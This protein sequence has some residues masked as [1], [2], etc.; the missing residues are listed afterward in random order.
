VSMWGSFARFGPRCL[1]QVSARRDAVQE[2][3]SRAA[4]L[5]LAAG[6]SS[7][8]RTHRR[9]S[10]AHTGYTLWWFYH[11]S[12]LRPCALLL[13]LLLVLHF[14]RGCCGWWLAV[15]VGAES[16]GSRIATKRSVAVAQDSLARRLTQAS[17]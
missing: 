8:R 3:P 17:S 7:L 9:E 14:L 6:S 12:R 13:S 10:T 1:R 15:G 11:A 2:E 4:V 5:R 16:L